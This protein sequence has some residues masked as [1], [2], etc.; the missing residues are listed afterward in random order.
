MLEKAM[1]TPDP[2]LAHSRTQ[3]QS[4]VYTKPH[5]V[6]CLLEAPSAALKVKVLSCS[7]L[8]N[9]GTS[10]NFKLA[11]QKKMLTFYPSPLASQV[12][13]LLLPLV[14][15]DWCLKELTYQMPSTHEN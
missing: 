5:P 11:T 4:H 2:V 3:A 8:P 10:S 12:R 13:V 15:R 9:L 14:H 1:L 6:H 7:H